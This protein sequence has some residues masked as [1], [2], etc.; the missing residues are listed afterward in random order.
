MGICKP[1]A[2]AKIGRCYCSTRPNGGGERAGVIP[3]A[4]QTLLVARREHVELE[5]EPRELRDGGGHA[6]LGTR[7]ECTRMDEGGSVQG[8]CGSPARCARTWRPKCGGRWARRWGRPRRRRGRGAGRASGE[9]LGARRAKRR[10]NLARSTGIMRQ[11]KPPLPSFCIGEDDQG[12]M[13]FRSELTFSRR[14][15]T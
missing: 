10:R 15:R 9:G 3:E 5:L 1:P 14:S 6:F 11:G 4:A 8:I 7:H 13:A 12:K 2:H